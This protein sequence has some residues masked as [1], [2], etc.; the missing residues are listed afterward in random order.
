[1]SEQVNKKPSLKAEKHEQIKILADAKLNTVSNHISK[2]PIDNH[3]SNEHISLI[4]SELDK[5]IRIKQEIKYK[6]KVAIDEETKQSL[7][8]KGVKMPY[9]IFSKYVW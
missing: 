4:S 5:F 6:I 9:S 3:I 1:M 8:A 7:I 2:V